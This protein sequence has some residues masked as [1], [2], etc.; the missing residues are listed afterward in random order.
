MRRKNEG[1][2]HQKFNQTQIEVMYKQVLLHIQNNSKH[3]L[4]PEEIEKG[5]QDTQ[6]QWQEN[7]I[8]LHYKSAKYVTEQKEWLVLSNNSCKSKLGRHATSIRTQLSKTKLTLRR[9][10]YFVGDIFS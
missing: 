6:N 4:H 2:F 10:R 1:L 8:E 5:L 7:N 3:Y 9:P